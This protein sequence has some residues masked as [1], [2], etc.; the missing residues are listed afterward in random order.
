MQGDLMD[1][2]RLRALV[3]CIPAGRWVSYGDV[4]RA[5]G[6]HPAA[7]RRLNG[8]LTRLA[9][10]GA[11]RVLRSAGRAAAPSLVEPVAVRARMEP[12]ALELGGYRASPASR[13]PLT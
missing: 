11:H 13:M 7:A 4:A 1:T 2:D 8:E 3:E 12:E 6:E 5:L 10:P 9:P